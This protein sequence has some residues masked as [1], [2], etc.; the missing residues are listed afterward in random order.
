MARNKTKGTDKPTA[1]IVGP[2][3]VPNPKVPDIRPTDQKVLDGFLKEV[4]SG[5]WGVSDE[6][7][8]N[9]FNDLKGHILERYRPHQTEHAM[10]AAIS[11]VGNPDVLAKGIRA[12]YGYSTGFKA[13]LVAII[14]IFGLTTVPLLQ[15]W[16]VIGPWPIL[17]LLVTFFLISTF[18]TQTGLRWGGLM[19]LAAAS[20]RF[21][22]VVVLVLRMP[23][24]Y[25]I[26]TTQALFDFILV[27]MF[28][29]LV[30]LLAGQIRETSVKEYFKEEFV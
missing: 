28:L 20:S 4:D 19:G 8:A 12:L 11:S 5:L 25:S 6:D 27:S 13:F 15:A 3:S 22:L 1:K 10:D 14:F 9:A 26:G 24:D 29:L 17:G 2:S 23:D 30:G 21:L 18:G 7:K 16:T